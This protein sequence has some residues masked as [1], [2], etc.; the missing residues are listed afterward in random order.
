MLELLSELGRRASQALAN[1]LSSS[2]A[3][4]ENLP[5]EL[6][7]VRAGK[8]EF[9][10]LQISE[11]LS[12]AKKL[13]RPPR[14]LADAVARA[15]DGHEALARVEVAGA[16]FVNLHLRDEWIGRRAAARLGDQRLGL[17]EIGAGRRVV[18]DFSSPNVAK[19][20]HI[21]HIRSTIIGDAIRRVLAALGYDAIADNHLGDWGT[22]F[23]KLIVAYRRWLDE[24]AYIKDPVA[25]LLRLYIRFVAE[26]KREREALTGTKAQTAETDD[27]EE[28]AGPAPPILVEARNELVKLQQGDPD[29][30]ALWRKFIADSRHAFEEVYARLGVRFDYW[31]GESTYNDLLPTV[32]AELRRRAIAVESRGA[33]VVLFDEAEKLPPFIVQKSDGG[34]NYAT[35]DIATLAL[36]IG[37]FGASRVI[38]VTDE[39]Q[40]LHFRQLF[41]VARRMGVEV[42]LEHVWFGLMRMAEGVIKTR[43]GNVIHLSDFL[44]E[45]ERRATLAAAEHNPELDESGRREV[46]RVVGIGAVKYNDLSRDRQSIV[47]FAWDKA[48]ALDGNTAPYLQY[49]YARIRSILRKAEVAPAADAA[50][51]W[52]LPVERDLA[53]RILAYPE[54]V[55]S[56][57][58]TCRPHLLCDYLYELA[59]AFSAFYQAAPVLKAESPSLRASRLALTEL[60]ARVL[61]A[62]LALL[63]IEV[64]ERM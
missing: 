51:E 39:R 29:N 19:P 10:D 57:A 58:R 63:G 8:P 7:V 47:T 12:L 53:K 27:D 55:E 26:E 30:H 1:H 60:T 42:P 45:A 59:T 11:C 25:E 62:G 28:V 43:E 21:G 2:S 61:R 18:I 31:L 9:G 5:D 52:A 17:R 41:A 6:Q 56:V 48:L 14:E 35:T 20:M 32:V 46:G 40:Q 4:T 23:G 24:A 22:Q 38:I 49:A 34:Y 36:R 33:L 44:D 3:S 64:L 13:K 50:I 54:A 15:L 16:G 37:L